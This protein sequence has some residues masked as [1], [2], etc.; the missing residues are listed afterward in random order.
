MRITD[1]KLDQMLRKEENPSS[2]PSFEFKEDGKKTASGVSRKVLT[3]TIAASLALVLIAASVFAATRRAAAPTDG[4]DTAG[5]TTES[6]ESAVAEV[7]SDTVKETENSAGAQ[8]DAQTD[9][10]TDTQDTAPEAPKRS[11]TVYTI[12]AS[13]NGS[14]GGDGY[15]NRCVAGINE[16][17]INRVTGG[18]YV[19]LSSA[20][21]G[22]EHAGH[23][24]LIYDAVE[25]TFICGS[26]ILEEKAGLI[27]QNSG[28]R[29]V[30]DNISTPETLLLAVWDDA[31]A[32]I[33]RRYI[34]DVRTDTLTEIPAPSENDFD[35]LAAS[36]DFR[37]VVSHAY[38]PTDVDYD[39][40]YVIDTLTGGVKNVSGDQPTFMLSRITP[41]GR[42]VLNA[43][44]Y[45]GSTN[46]FDSEHCRFLATDMTG[47]TVTECEGKV[48]RYGAGLLLTRDGESVHHLYD[49]SAG[50]EIGIPEGT[51]YWDGADGVLYR[52]DAYNGKLTP[53]GEKICALYVSED[54]ESAFTYEFGAGYIRRRDLSG[55]ESDVALDEAFV[56]EIT[57]MSGTMLFS[58]MLQEKDDV[59][60]LLY[61]T[62][63]KPSVNPDDPEQSQKTS[64]HDAVF[65]VLKN[66]KASSIKEAVT[67]LQEKYPENDFGFTAAE[68][69]GYVALYID[70]K[71]NG[72]KRVFVEDYR[73]NT[74]SAYFEGKDRSYVRL[75]SYSPG[76]F[77]RRK[78]KS[79]EAETRAFLL[80]NRMKTSAAD[81][82]YAIFYENGE[83]SEEKVK[84]YMFAAESA[85]KISFFYA[86]CGGHGTETYSKEY[87]AKFVE[88]MAEF[89]ACGRQKTKMLADDEYTVYGKIRTNTDMELVAAKDKKGNCYVRVNYDS[90]YKV[91][92]YVFS[93]LTSL[94]LSAFAANGYRPASLIPFNGYTDGFGTKS[95]DPMTTDAL[96]AAL[97][98]GLT[99]DEFAGFGSELFV[100]SINREN[101]KFSMVTTLVA[102][103]DPDGTR[104]FV[105][106][107]YTGENKD[108]SKAVLY[109]GSL[110]FCCD[111]LTEGYT[112]IEA[113]GRMMLPE[114]QF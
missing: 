105:L 15:F 85:G 42:F 47:T 38:R 41:D 11:M 24:C 55:E 82:D 35:T 34:F 18:R 79:T 59:I 93:D 88:F 40:V 52:G 83:F 97:K 71:D 108:V 37:Y 60:L 103:Q 76:N 51:Y 28:E 94:A 92:E 49:L 27:L 44:K 73:D 53:V 95:N 104:G 39:D 29:I 63:E 96:K 61:T 80:K 114:Y 78:L 70:A 32:A 89:A 45:Y 110:R 48:L 101:P 21:I 26:C 113:K 3:G 46:N 7:P 43:L 62:T 106:L 5:L 77:E 30:I 6:A 22:S 102:V 19:N 98:N 87:K 33:V 100:V 90:V 16:A 31:S 81:I 112:G 2:A 65:D 10:P 12:S 9:P 64:N 36:G 23:G 50:K 1:D 4:E 72:T 68:G 57:E 17:K 99:Y 13:S 74:F 8:T 54:G 25:D 84:D 69:S 111:L 14:S 75:L 67:L 91:P 58:F 56:N 86:F 66:G 109:D 107:V 20:M